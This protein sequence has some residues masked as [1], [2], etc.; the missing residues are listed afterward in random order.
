MAIISDLNPKINDFT[1]IFN[2][3]IISKKWVNVIKA[4]LTKV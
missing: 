1:C 4:L 2:G 3:F